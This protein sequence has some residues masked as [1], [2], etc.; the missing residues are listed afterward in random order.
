MQNKNSKIVENS[1][2]VK[3][4]IESIRNSLD[5]IERAVT[6][7][8][9]VSRT[10]EADGNTMSERDMINFIIDNS[11]P[12]WDVSFWTSLLSNIDKYGSLT[13]NQRK[14]MLAQYSKSK[15]HKNKRK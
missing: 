9:T 3:L 7:A 6:G 15:Y 1:M 10:K 5:K 2:F 8:T 4:E 12:T 11:G 13:E 14:I